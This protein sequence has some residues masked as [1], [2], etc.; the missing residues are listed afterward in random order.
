[1][2]NKFAL[3]YYSATIISINFHMAKSNDKVCLM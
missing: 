3:S 2:K 1:M